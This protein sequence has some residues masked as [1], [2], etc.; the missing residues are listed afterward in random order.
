[1]HNVGIQY[2][3]SSRPVK[4]KDAPEKQGKEKQESKS[5]YVD[6]NHTL[7]VQV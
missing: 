2:K 4:G 3:T 5:T 1:M 6:F 7:I